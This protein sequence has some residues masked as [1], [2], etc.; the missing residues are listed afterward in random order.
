MGD[1]GGQNY[2]NYY[3]DGNVSHICANWAPILGFS[4]IVA[5][6]AFASKS[7]NVRKG[8]NASRWLLLDT[9]LLS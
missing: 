8:A 2:D 3:E 5:S 9:L 4:G 1:D 7:E 6:V